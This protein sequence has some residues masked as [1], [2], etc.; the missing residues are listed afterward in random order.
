[1]NVSF[2]RVRDIK[3]NAL[4]KLRRNK[5]IRELSKEYRSHKRWSSMLKLQYRPEYFEAIQR[6]K[7]RICV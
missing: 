2:Q 3:E 5:Y 6:Y 4:K 7:E 1:M